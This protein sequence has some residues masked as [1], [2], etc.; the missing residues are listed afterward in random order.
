MRCTVTMHSSFAF[1]LLLLLA[2][3]A[4]ALVSLRT[5]TTLR[6]VSKRKV[7]DFIATCDNWPDIVLS[8]VGVKGRKTDTPMKRGITVDEIFGLPPLLPLTV[9]WKCVTS[10]SRK[11]VLDVTSVLGVPGLASNC[12]MRFDIQESSSV[13]V[14]T[15]VDLTMEYDPENILALLAIPVLSLDNTLAL[16]VLLPNAIN[17]ATT[18]NS[19]S[20]KV[21]DKTPLQ[22]FELLMGGLYGVA[23]LAHFYDLLLGDSKLLVAGGAPPFSALPQTGQALALLWCAVGPA[24]MILSRAGQG[25]AG[26]ILYG[27]VEVACAVVVHSTCAVQGVTPAPEFDPV[28]N[29]IGVQV[30][31]LASWFYSASKVAGGVKEDPTK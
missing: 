9:S 1:L 14:E 22:E 31:V 29:A 13:P 25:T 2:L 23:G 3:T 6:N 17:R 18:S 4:D 21:V 24:A 15:K 20:S 28:V 12:R 16:Q 19:I 26:L 8:S 10:D 5:S 11:G 7:F 30:V 27:A